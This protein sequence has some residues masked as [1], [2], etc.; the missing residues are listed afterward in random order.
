MIMEIY[1]RFEAISKF[2]QDIVARLD[3]LDRKHNRPL[4]GSNYCMDE[5]ITAFIDVKE[6]K[7]RS[8]YFLSK[9][10]PM[11]QIRQYVELFND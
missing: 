5:Y 11:S 10:A 1:N 7:I 6:G 8:H 3:R 9:G 2:G 4:V